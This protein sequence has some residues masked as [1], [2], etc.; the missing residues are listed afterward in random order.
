MSRIIIYGEVTGTAGAAATEI[1]EARAASA[2]GVRDQIA[3]H[4]KGCE[5][6]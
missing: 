1:V 2:G 3:L 5:R 4:N 6:T